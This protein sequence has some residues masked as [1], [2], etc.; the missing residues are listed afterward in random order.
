MKPTAAIINTSRGPIIDGAALLAAL[1]ERPHR[2]GRHSTSTRASRCRP[3]T[4]CD[5][6]PRALLTPHLGYVTEETYRLFYGGTVAAIEGWLAGKPV[7][8]ITT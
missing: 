8:Q 5:R 1:R 6:E 7:N 3:T 2:G 4:R